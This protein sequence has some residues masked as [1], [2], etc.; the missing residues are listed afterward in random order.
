MDTSLNLYLPNHGSTPY[1]N[2]NTEIC[3]KFIPNLFNAFKNLTIF[4]DSNADNNNL[5]LKYGN[6]KLIQDL[7]NQCHLQQHNKYIVN[8]SSQFAGRVIDHVYSHKN[9]DPYKIENGGHIG[10]YNYHSA[11]ITTLKEKKTLFWAT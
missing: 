6:E 10:K 8:N 9:K 4:S 5:S 1:S 2:L 3:K 11:L 7:L